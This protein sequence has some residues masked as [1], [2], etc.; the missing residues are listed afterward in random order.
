V[1]QQVDLVMRKAGSGSTQASATRRCRS[2]PDAESIEIEER[3]RQ[4]ATTDMPRLQLPDQ[5]EADPIRS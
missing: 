2:R 5:R 4:T 1:N 3:R